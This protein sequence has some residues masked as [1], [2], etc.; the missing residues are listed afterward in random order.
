MYL[1]YVS[2][3]VWY[4]SQWRPQTKVKVPAELHCSLGSISTLGENLRSLRLL[5]AF[6]SCECRLRSSFPSWPSAQVRP[7]FCR[8]PACLGSWPPYSIFKTS[9]AGWIL[10]MVWLSLTSPSLVASLLLTLLP[11]SF[12]FKGPC[13]FTAPTQEIRNNSP[14]L[15]L[16]LSAKFPLP[17]DITYSQVPGMA[18]LRRGALFCLPHDDINIFSLFALSKIAIE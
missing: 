7:S 3:E 17:C 14:K 18:A 9:T 15:S 16:T 10:A 6:S 11:F 5:A 1:S 2:A 4:G 8:P 13:D 12:T